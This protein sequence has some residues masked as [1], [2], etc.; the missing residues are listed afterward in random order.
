MSTF[1]MLGPD[2]RIDR[3]R[4][5]NL[6]ALSDTSTWFPNAVSAF[7]YTMFAIPAIASGTAP[8]PGRGLLPTA[9]DYPD[10]L[11][12][13]LGGAYD[14]HVAE[15]ITALCPPS[16]CGA[17]DANRR[18]LASD[19]VV[20]YLHT[21][22]PRDL[23]A[24]HLPSLGYSWK[25][26]G[27]PAAPPISAAQRAAFRADTV[28]NE[29]AEAGRPEAFRSFVAGVQRA[30]RPSLHFVHS[31]LPHDPYQHLASGRVYTQPALTSGLS[32]DNVWNKDPWIVDMGRRRHIEQ[33]R[34]ADKLLGELVA[35]L[36]E[37]DLF[38][39][40]LVVVTSDHGG[41]FVPGEPHRTA[42]PATY[43][44]ADRDA[45][46]GQ[47]AAP[48]QRRR[49]PASGVGPRHRPDHRPGRW[50]PCAVGSGR[51][52]PPVGA[53]SDKTDNGICRRVAAA[54]P[55]LRRADRGRAQG[56]RAEP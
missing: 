22:M 21:V 55:G 17:E 40:A 25:G 28:F 18:L 46:P 19:L 41:A 12:T 7:P 6:A 34:F 32:K 8:D 36:K 14:L 4:Y 52:V 42:T 45:A 51:A 11:F 9:G 29:A 54:A 35:K 1:T 37:E 20:L 38:D 44:E 26:F 56:R 10:N 47:A 53:C 33:E 27:G 24:N 43:K 30:D 16:L 3:Q 13:W 15:P 39:R 48:A 31:L 5:P 50:R 23:A 2:G 49:R